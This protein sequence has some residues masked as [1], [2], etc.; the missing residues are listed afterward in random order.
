MLAIM[1]TMKKKKPQRGRLVFT[2]ACHDGW[3]RHPETNEN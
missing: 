3:R 1:I 2:A